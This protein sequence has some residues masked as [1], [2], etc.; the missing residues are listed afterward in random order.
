[1]KLLSDLYQRYMD[2]IYGVCLKYMEDPEEAKDCVISIFEEL[3]PK[4]KKYQV[5]NFKAWLYQLAKNHCLMKIRARKN[6][7]KKPAVGGMPARENSETVSTQLR[8][9]FVL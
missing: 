8:N 5:E 7:P 9:G 3:I 4:L 6:L 2:L 1:M